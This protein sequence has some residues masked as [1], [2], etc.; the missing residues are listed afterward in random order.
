MMNAMEKNMATRINQEPTQDRLDRDAPWP[1]GTG[2]VVV[3]FQALISPSVGAREVIEA[4]GVAWA[5]RELGA[6]TLRVLRSVRPQ[7]R[8]FIR[9]ASGINEN[10]LQAV[11]ATR[12]GGCSLALILRDASLVSEEKLKLAQSCGAQ[13][14][15]NLL[16]QL[17]LRAGV[18]EL[19]AAEPEGA[20][21]EAKKREQEERAVLITSLIDAVAAAGERAVGGHLSVGVVQQDCE[22]PALWPVQPQQPVE[23]PVAS[24]ARRRLTAVLLKKVS[25]SVM[26]VREFV[27]GRVMFVS[28]RGAPEVLT[29][30]RLLAETGPVIL[31]VEGDETGGA[32]APLQLITLVGPDTDYW[33]VEA[34][35]FASVLRRLIVHWRLLARVGLLPPLSFPD[36]PTGRDW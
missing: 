27:S 11:I 17:Q 3:L 33:T 12:P 7:I 24:Q 25:K 32:R 30:L 15:E 6:R 2:N 29:D 19:P 23:N 13:L 22:S 26:R 5:D 35:H 34:P 31:E 18:A 8:R 14:G 1:P 10:A 28:F 36:E 20:L 9:R 16:R 4:D 21:S